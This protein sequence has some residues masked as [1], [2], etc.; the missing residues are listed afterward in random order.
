MDEGQGLSKGNYDGLLGREFVDELV[1]QKD[2]CA[3]EVLWRLND[4]NHCAA[5]IPR[6]LE[7]R[8]DRLTALVAE[9]LLEDALNSTLGTAL[10]QRLSQEDLPPLPVNM[11]TPLVARL[12]KDEP[13]TPELESAR[14]ALAVWVI[15]QQASV[16][17]ALALDLLA[18]KV[19]APDESV[20]E[21][22][23]RRVARA[24]RSFSIAVSN[25]RQ[26][27]AESPSAETWIAA[28]H[29]YDEGARKGRAASVLRPLGLDLLREAPLLN[30]SGSFSDELAEFTRGD[31]SS[32]ALEVLR[33]AALPDQP[34][35]RALVLSCLTD[36]SSVRFAC[37]QALARHQPQLWPLAVDGCSD[38]STSVWRRFLSAMKAPIHDEAMTLLITE[39]PAEL[40]HPVLALALD[41]AASDE[42]SCLIEVS[43]RLKALIDDEEPSL[44]PKALLDTVPWRSLRKE[45]RPSYLRAILDEALT[46][47]QHTGLVAAAYEANRVTAEVAVALI[48][49]DGEATTLGGVAPGAKRARLAG[50]LLRDTDEEGETE[51]VVEAIRKA[52]KH[53]FG[54]DLAA[55][56]AATSPAIAFSGGLDAYPSLSQ[57]DKNRLVDLLERHGTIDELELLEAVV[58]DGQKGAVERRR[59]AAVRIGAL[60]GHRG[61][62]PGAVLE[63]LASANAT[64][65]TT[66]IGI[67]EDVQPRDEDAISRLRDL[68]AQGGIP[69]Q[70]SAK[71]LGAIAEDIITELGHEPAKAASLDLLPLLGR[72]G[73]PIVF[74]YLFEFVGVDPHWD[75]VEVRRAAANAIEDAA[76]VAREISLDDQDTLVHLSDGEEAEVDPQAVASLRS[77]LSRVQLGEDEALTILYGFL[78]SPPNIDPNTLFG[79][80]KETLVIHLAL[81]ARAKRSKEHGRVLAQLDIVAAALAR[82]SY[83]HHGQ[84]D[85][86]KEVIRASRD[87]KD[88]ANLIGAIGNTPKMK[89]IQASL[90][91]IHELRSEK[92]QEAHPG[93]K[94]EPQDVVAAEQALRK[95]ATH[96]VQLLETAVGR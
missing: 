3:L 15:E 44:D 80:E 20:L 14:P 31:G 24:A 57:E 90:Q 60:I 55:V 2:A 5:L 1:A 32:T 63:L 62:I 95:V 91:V 7:V 65:R 88:Y 17:E 72:T 25:A 39:A 28:E 9:N 86:L 92:S 67:V 43:A 64:L 6:M 34:G 12:R 70:L 93:E 21:A 51:L 41:L 78:P 16:S 19:D 82:A 11:V 40:L 38:W 48:P 83:L 13:F 75:D 96:C 45:N 71:A 77:A 69:G 33:G 27:L 84:S 4:P 68:S 54:I 61:T 66:A 87:Q 29:L 53:A 52:Q 46:A 74:H 8:D 76:E 22:C 73:R 26:M 23:R 36:G 50:Q 59:R 35:A 42:D 79:A 49:D 30:A 37:A 58:V 94:A 56:I 10:A 81:Y 18:G 85:Q 47:D 89:S